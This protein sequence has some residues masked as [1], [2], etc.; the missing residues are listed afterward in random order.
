MHS[1]ATMRRRVI[2]SSTIGN[3]LE[4]FDFIVFGL[5]A[6][7]IGHLFFPETDPAAG[8]LAAYGLLAVAYIARPIGG[9]VFGVWADRIGRKR[10]LI[11]IVLLMAFSTS[12]IGILPTYDRIGVAAPLLLLVARLVQGFSAG[13]EFGTSTAMLIEFAPPG[14]RGLYASFQFVAQAIAFAGGAA[15]AFALNAGL[16][17]AALQ[18]WGWRLPFLAGIVIGPVGFYLRRKVDETPEFKAFMAERAGLPNTPLRDVLA[19]HP[20]ELISLILVVSGLTCYTYLG[21]I[22]YPNFLNTALGLKVANAQLGVLVLNLIAAVVLPLTAA[23]SDRIGRRITMIPALFVY[24]AV[25][26]LLTRQLLAAPSNGAMWSLQA[27]SIIMFFM[28]GPG[29]ALLLET[30]PVNVRSTG[31]SIVY[32]VAVAVFGGLAPLVVGW[33]YQTTH[34]KL[35][36][37]YCITGGL[38]LTLIGLILVP[39]A[40]TPSAGADEP[41]IV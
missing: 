9:I 31:A 8:L 1:D 10:A 16:S 19:R 6:G 37:F 39:P 29:G 24:A 18:S 20:R 2:W 7:V 12:V 23:L 21:T 32:N 40:H 27:A 30:F 28:I 15:C 17:P 25:S 13:G 41:S 5:F 22:F 34:D 4:W 35:V 14:R 36:P 3:A 26:L 11:T 33:L 38:V